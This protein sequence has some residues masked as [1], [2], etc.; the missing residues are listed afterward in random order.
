MKNIF[1]ICFFLLLT[2]CVQA[3][4]TVTYVSF[5]PPRDVAH[6][7][8]HLTQDQKKSFRMMHLDGEMT[9]EWASEDANFA[10]VPGGLILGA[11]D[12]SIVEFKSATI[13]TYDT[14]L[15]FGIRVFRAHN[16]IIVTANGQLKHISMGGGHDSFCDDTNCNAAVISSYDVNWPL[17][18]LNFPAYGMTFNIKSS[19]RGEFANLTIGNGSGIYSPNTHFSKFIPTDVP[20]NPNG[21][22]TN[23]STRE[24]TGTDKLEWRRL[25]IAGTEECLLYLTF[26]PPDLP[27]DYALEGGECQE[28]PE[29]EY[30]GGGVCTE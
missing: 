4:R 9:P 6:N 2:V 19:G 5:F 20:T 16:N 18:T 15:P 25:R 28:P 10:E 1:Y 3:Q 22:I 30:C 23:I 17:T 14:V 26:N 11:A 7:T 27:P 29:I 21:D 13:T 8:V 12:S 24:M